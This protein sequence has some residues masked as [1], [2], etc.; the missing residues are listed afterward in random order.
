MNV[1]TGLGIIAL[2]FSVSS[3]RSQDPDSTG[4]TNTS[5]S[6]EK[7][8]IITFN[9]NKIDGEYSFEQDNGNEVRQMENPQSSEYVEE[10]SDRETPFTTVSVYYMDNGSIKVS[11]KKFY[12]MPIGKWQYYSLEGELEKE[13][14]WDED[15]KFSIYDLANSLMENN[16]NIMSRQRG[17]DVQRS[18]VAGPRY[19]VLYPVD[20][21]V[22]PYDYYNLVIDGITGEEIEKK[23]ISVRR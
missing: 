1:I 11:G 21:K 4:K 20:V 22:R 10:V 6:M 19:I 9:E 18:D 2:I 13:V 16:I 8:D 12:L 17:L 5:I 7:F 23:I 14:D 15:Y 3:C